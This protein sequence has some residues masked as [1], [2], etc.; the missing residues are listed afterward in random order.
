MFRRRR[1]GDDASTPADQ[2]PDESAAADG[3][4][5][6]DAD[7]A[8][9]TDRT[10]GPYDASEVDM[11]EARSGRIDLGGLL[12]RPAPGMKLQLQLDKRTG[13]GTSVLL[14]TDEAAV[15]LVAVAAPRSS[16]MWEQTRLQI[17]EDAKGRGGRSEE[18]N[19]PFGT[20]MRV[21]VPAQ[22]Q[23]G[24]QVF[25]PSRVSG[26]DGPRWML[27]ATFL[28]KATT[29][30]SV[31]QQLVDIVRQTVVVRG[32]APMA[33]GDVITLKPPEGGQGEAETSQAGPS[34][35]GPLQA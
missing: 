28:G 17:G 5:A 31:F 20:E 30:A 14:S 35:D 21:V 27:R 18:A 23:E 16:G 7:S 33:P 34:E 10:G 13:N 1:R 11:Q 19:G 6:P 25:Q 15:Q 26:I 32:E 3:E 8:G 29:D 9:D 24:K 2:G 22:S 4:P 12:V